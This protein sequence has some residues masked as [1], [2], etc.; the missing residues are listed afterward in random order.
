MFVDTVY[1]FGT[2]SLE[3]FCTANKHIRVSM[4][5]CQEEE[6]EESLLFSMSVL[7]GGI[8]YRTYR[9]PVYTFFSNKET[10]MRIDYWPRMRMHHAGDE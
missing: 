8:L 5:E 6:K 7:E 3:P 9:T 4:Q 1:C 2:I 10:G